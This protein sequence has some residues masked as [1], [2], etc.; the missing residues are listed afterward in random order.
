MSKGKAPSP[1]DPM[2][3]ASAQTGSNIGTAI[4]SNILGQTNQQTP[5]GNLSYSQRGTYA[6]KDPLSGKTYNLP[7]FNATDAVA[8][9]AEHPQPD[10]R[11]AAQPRRD[12]QRAF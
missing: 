9:P 5:Y 7:L 10:A 6:Y 11:R 12:R 2:Q 3:T 4:A 8:H 1:P